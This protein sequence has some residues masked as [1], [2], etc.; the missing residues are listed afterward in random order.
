[1]SKYSLN[2]TSVGFHTTSWLYW[3]CL[4]RRP[5][6]HHGGGEPLQSSSNVVNWRASSATMPTYFSVAVSHFGSTPLTRCSAPCCE[7]CRVLPPENVPV[8]KHMCHIAPPKHPSPADWA[9]QCTQAWSFASH[10][11]DAEPTPCRVAKCVAPKPCLF[12]YFCCSKASR[13]RVDCM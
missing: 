3:T 4:K 13:C 10:Y 11:H 6:C 12:I 7:I 8:C 2:F 1:M 5:K 9:S